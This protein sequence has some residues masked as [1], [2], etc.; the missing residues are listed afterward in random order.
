MCILY[1]GVY[2]AGKTLHRH[3]EGQARA[4]SCQSFLMRWDDDRKNNILTHGWFTLMFKFFLTSSPKNK[5]AKRFAL[6]AN[7]LSCNITSHKTSKYVCRRGK[8][9]MPW[10]HATDGCTTETIVWEK[11]NGIGLPTVSCWSCNCWQKWQVESDST[12]LLA[13]KAVR[14][15]RYYSTP[16]CAN[17]RNVIAWWR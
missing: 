12:R 9:Q 13:E 14:N 2:E 8:T 4:R 17:E 15:D 1:P 3:H 16:T 11:I 7:Q 6:C 10:K 5:L